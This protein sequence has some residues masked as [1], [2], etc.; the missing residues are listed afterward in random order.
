MV[1]QEENYDIFA[2]QVQ[3]GEPHQV[4]EDAVR[5][6]AQ[7]CAVEEDR[8]P[9]SMVAKLRTVGH[10]YRFPPMV[11]SFTFWDAVNWMRHGGPGSGF[12]IAA[13]RLSLASRL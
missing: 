1:E 13:V 10:R 6:V 2:C 4:S 11:K 3:T 12:L 8:N 7:D 9:I 5:K